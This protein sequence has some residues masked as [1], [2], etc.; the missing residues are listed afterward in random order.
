M[1]HFK[2][3]LNKANRLL[4]PLLLFKFWE[5]V[6]FFLVIMLAYIVFFKIRDPLLTVV[7]WTTGEYDWHVYLHDFKRLRSNYKATRGPYPTPLWYLVWLRFSFRSHA[8]HPPAPQSCLL[9]LRQRKKHWIFHFLVIPQ[10]T[11]TF[12]IASRY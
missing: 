5:V 2:R 6:F 9:E 1:R 3:F 8:K 10:L 12:S 7:G 4:N 11:L